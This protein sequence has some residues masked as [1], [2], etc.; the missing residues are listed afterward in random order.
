MGLG[1]TIQMLALMA[2][3]R[4][5]G[6]RRPFLVVAPTSVL[7]TWR[8]EAPRLTPDLRVAVVDATRAKRGITV[9]DAAASADLVITSYTLLRLDEPEFAAVEWAGFRARR[10]EVRQAVRPRPT[11]AVPR[12]RADVDVVIMGTLMENSL[13]ELSRASPSCWRQGCS[14]RRPPGDVGLD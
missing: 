5:G 3:V 1:K 4:E 10:A 8:A 7:S 9:T 14:P 13:N 6:A 2:H 11:R 12:L